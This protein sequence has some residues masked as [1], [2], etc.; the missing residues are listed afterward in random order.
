MSPDTPRP[1]ALR[2]AIQALAASPLGARLSAP[3]LHHADRLLIRLSGG[4]LSA[5]SLLLGLPAAALTTT[6]AR[7]GRGRTVPLVALPDGDGFILVASNWGQARLPGWCHNLR[8]N[9]RARLLYRGRERVYLAREAGPAEYQRYWQK[10]TAAYPGYAAYR[11]RIGPGGRAIP[12]FVLT[13]AGSD[14]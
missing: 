2:R 1:S 12:I 13:P 7:S 8:A 14:E 5:P 4:R 9:P 11:R 3:L 6:G 10:A